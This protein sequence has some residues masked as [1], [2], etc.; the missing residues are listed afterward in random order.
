M[1]RRDFLKAVAVSSLVP[2]CTPADPPLPDV[3]WVGM[4][5]SH[6]ALSEYQYA[7]PRKLIRDGAIQCQCFQVAYDPDPEKMRAAITVNG[8]VQPI[9]VRKAPDDH[10]LAAQDR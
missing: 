3:L 6:G 1:K 10:P 9:K 7:I 8:E 5:P 2:A 4:D